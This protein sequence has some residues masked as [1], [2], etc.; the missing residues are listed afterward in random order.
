MLQN[1]KKAL[2]NPEP[3]T[4]TFQTWQARLTMSGLGGKTDSPFA[5]PDF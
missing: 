4:G 3:S 2:A 1:V 5:R